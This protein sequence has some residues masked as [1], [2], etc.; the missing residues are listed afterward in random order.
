MT[1]S[2]LTL[3]K[4]DQTWFPHIKELLQAVDL[5]TQDLNEKIHLYYS[6]GEKVSPIAC[7][8]FEQYDQIGLL[9]SVAIHQDAQGKG[10]GKQ[11]VSQLMEEAKKMGMRELYL[12]TTTAEHF[13]QKMG[14]E[15]QEREKV[16]QAIKDSEEFSS[17]CPSTAILMCKKL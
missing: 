8:G 11:W 9:R 13:F 15:K 4:A 1:P 17:L 14:F 3:K 5:P 16:P 12:L 7:G 6:Q 10:I 2:T